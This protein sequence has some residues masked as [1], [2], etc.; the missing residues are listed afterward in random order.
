MDEVIE[1]VESSRKRGRPPG[2]K[3]KSPRQVVKRP[4][5][6][7]AGPES[8][9]PVKKRRMVKGNYHDE[10]PLKMLTEEEKQLE[11]GAVD[12]RHYDRQIRRF[13]LDKF[14]D[15][16]LVATSE[17]LKG[18]PNDARR[19]WAKALHEACLLKTVESGGSLDAITRAVKVIVDNLTEQKESEGAAY[20]EALRLVAQR[21]KKNDTIL[22]PIE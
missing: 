20:E 22:G 19:E 2:S 9:E 13:I 21:E 6:R 10:V 1:Q 15:R 4:R 17:I 12:A 7:K 5:A 16:D 8:V 14:A 11:E 18:L 3:D